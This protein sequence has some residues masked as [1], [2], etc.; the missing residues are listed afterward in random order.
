MELDDDIEN[1][2][3]LNTNH[4]D[5]SDSDDTSTDTS[6]E[7]IQ[8]FAKNDDKCTREYKKNEMEHGEV[9]NKI[10]EQEET[11]EWDNIRQDQYNWN[12]YFRYWCDDHSAWNKKCNGTEFYPGK[13]F[14]SQ[15]FDL[16]EEC[17]ETYG[18]IDDDDVETIAFRYA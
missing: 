18:S 6:T 1:L 16:F 2:N 5:E 8:D 10:N 17:S 14:D 11:K 12:D 7:N 13:Q 15:K 9:H 3:V 4:F